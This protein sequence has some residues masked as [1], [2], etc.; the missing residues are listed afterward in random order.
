MVIYH[1]DMTKEA[2]LMATQYPVIT[3][4]GPRQAGKTTLA[5]II[6]NEQLED[7]VVLGTMMLQQDHVDGLVSGAVNTT[8]NTIRPAL[9][10]IKTAENASLVSSVFFM[11]LPDQV[12]VYGDCAINP[13]PTAEQLADIAIQSAESVHVRFENHERTFKLWTRNCGAPW[14]RSA[15]TP[16]K[17]AN[18]LSPIVLLA[19]RA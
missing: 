1:R 2:K 6:A 14:W 13:D 11:L 17:G 10:L 3:I 18:S 7:N 5:N 12:L 9:Q 19:A 15:L 16:N 8:A 4:L